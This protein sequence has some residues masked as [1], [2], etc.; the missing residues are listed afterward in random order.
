MKRPKRVR[1]LFDREDAY[2]LEQTAKKRGMSVPQ[3]VRSIVSEYR[4]A[5]E[6]SI[7]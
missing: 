3:L 5:V 4:N 7:G 1:L 6:K 2:F